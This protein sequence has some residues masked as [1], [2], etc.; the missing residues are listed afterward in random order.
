[1]ELRKC[2]W[3]RPKPFSPPP[4]RNGKCQRT[5]LNAIKETPKSANP[6]AR[7]CM[8]LC[9]SSPLRALLENEKKKRELAEK[10]KEKIEREKEEL[11]ERLRQIEEQTKKAQQGRRARNTHTPRLRSGGSTSEGGGAGCMWRSR[12]RL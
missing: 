1:M 9:L 12:A 11:M 7:L 8:S 6:W 5:V 2:W 4:P 10:E 3:G